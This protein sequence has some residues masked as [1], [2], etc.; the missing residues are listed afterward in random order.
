MDTLRET[1]GLTLDVATHRNPSSWDNLDLEGQIVVCVIV[2]V[3]FIALT[4]Y[5]MFT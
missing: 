2:A 4:L 5:M 3:F 1:L